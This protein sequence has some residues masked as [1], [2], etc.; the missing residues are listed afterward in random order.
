MGMQ[1]GIGA[2]HLP[3]TKIT[4]CCYYY[5]AGH[6][7]RMKYCRSAFKILTGKQTFCKETSRKAKKYVVQKYYNAS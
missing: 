3:E 6:V 5:W 1:C 2:D 7:A 4:Y